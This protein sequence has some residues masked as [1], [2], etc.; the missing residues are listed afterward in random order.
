MIAF[1]Q[2]L[3]Q[4]PIDEG[5]HEKGENEGHCYRPDEGFGGKNFREQRRIQEPEKHKSD[6]HK[7]NVRYGRPDHK[8]R[9]LAFIGWCLIHPGQPPPLRL[10]RANF[11][12]LEF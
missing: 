10:L 7:Q 2:K 12:F 3:E 9:D 11:G 6:Y 1:P 5:G 4:T 8:E